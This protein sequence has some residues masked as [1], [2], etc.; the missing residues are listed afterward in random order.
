MITKEQKESIS[1]THVIHELNILK[2]QNEELSK[3]GFELISAQTK[4]H[5]LLH[6][7]T[8]GIITFAQNGT[9]ET[10]NIAA[11]NIFGY[12]EAEVVQRKISDLIPCP[13]WVEDNVGAYITYFISSRASADIPLLG[14][15]RIGFDILLDVSIGQSSG[16]N[17]VLF[18]DI[19]DGIELFSDDRNE[20]DP[21]AD[22][23]EKTTDT[24]QQNDFIVCFFRDITLDKKLE[25]E[26]EDHRHALDLAAGV[27]KRDKDFRVIDINDH[28][29]QM[30]GRN[31]KEF[32]GEQFIELK[33]SGRTNNELQLKQKR[34]FLSQ[35]NPWVGE[36]SFLNKQGESVWFTES[37]TPFMDNQNSPYQYLSILIN[38]TDRK[39]F[40][41]ELEEH[42]DNLQGLV[43]EQI[44]D[45]KQAKETAESANIAK[46]EFLANMSHELRTPMHGIISFTQLCLK[47]FKN[48]PLDEKKTDKLHKFVTNID[49][50]SQRLLALL[51]DLLDLSKLES[52]KEEFNLEKNDI[53]LLSQQIHNEMLAKVQEKSI[54]FTILLPENPT[55]I[56]CDK[57]KILQVLSNLINNAVKFSPE[58]KSINISFENTKIISGRR[59]NDTEEKEGII[60]S[61]TDQGPG[62]PDNELLTVF[63][64]FIQS[65]KTKNGAGGTGLGLSICKEITVKHKGKIWAEHNPEGGSIFKLF[66]PKEDI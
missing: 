60:M 3:T 36:S 13:D 26:L 18:N 46:G 56:S 41:S 34:E 55:I 31:R 10:F 54:K 44:T 65:S 6:N 62:I 38:I 49:T 45:I 21:F 51:N 37:T 64:K 50:S 42:R 20:Q 25:K 40:E 14:K 66:L 24:E 61:I 47:Q 57:N 29:C 35:G 27:I 39:Q 11:Q 30:L 2:K 8:D 22:E 7:A 33:F 17:T 12:S 63:D 23:Y 52:G 19:E 53:H 5:S 32:V 58:N 28:F 4:L 15:H 59:A 16:H 9:V 48:L 1:I 43:N